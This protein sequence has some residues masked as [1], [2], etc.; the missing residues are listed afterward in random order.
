MLAMLVMGYLIS[1]DMYCRLKNKYWLILPTVI[2]I[3]LFYIHNTAFFLV[4]AFMLSALLFYREWKAV[5]FLAAGTAAA[6]VAYIPWMPVLLQQMENTERIIGWIEAFWTWKMIGYTFTAFVPGGYMPLYM[7]IPQLPM[8]LQWM[9]YVLF[10]VIIRYG[11][12][13]AVLKRNNAVGFLALFMLISLLIPY[14][15]SFILTPSYLAGRTDFMVFPVWCVLAGYGISSFPNRT[16]QYGVLFILV[17]AS[18]VVIGI[19]YLTPLEKSEDELIKTL[20]YHANDGDVVITTGL[21][22]PIVEYEMEGEDVDILSYPPDMKD[23]L[24]HLNA[25]WYFENAELREDAANVLNQAVEA[26]DGNGK[27]LLIWS[28]RPVNLPLQEI[29]DSERFS[30]LH[31]NVYEHP[32]MGLSRLNEPLSI[33]ILRKQ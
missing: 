5:L 28:E 20:R 23:H 12:Y 15:L 6:V 21:T 27:I 2:L 22:R 24:A 32:R 7:D 9:L 1:G 30:N 16:M 26:M 4:P 33:W 17:S 8:G 3:L 19:H 13:T 25:R 18:L 10:A 14:T 11:I 31:R 29:L